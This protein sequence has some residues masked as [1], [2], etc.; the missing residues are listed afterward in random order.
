MPPVS[1]WGTEGTGGPRLVESPWSREYP[2]MFATP[3]AAGS[4]HPL[5]ALSFLADF[6]PPDSL[7][8][9]CLL[10]IP[11]VVLLLGE[12]GGV[13][14]V[15][16]GRVGIVEKRWSSC[17]PV[18][19]GGVI[20]LDGESGF[21]ADVLRAGFHF[22]LWR[23][24]Y[25]LHKVPLVTVAPG[26]IGYVYARGGE[27]LPAGQVLGRVVECDNYQNARAFLGRSTSDTPLSPGQRGR[28]RAI[29]REGTYAMNL[30]LFAVLTEE[31]VYHLNLQGHAELEKL[32]HR[33]HDLKKVG[34]FDP[35]AIPTNGRGIVTV[36]DGPPLMPGEGDAPEVDAKPQD[37][38]AFLQAG[39]KRGRQQ[40]VLIEG[41]YFLNRWFATVE[42]KTIPELAD[43]VG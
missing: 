28:Q 13:R 10:A 2:S 37:A 33:Q 9:F 19:E 21:Q 29:L 40:A 4:S 20:A 11:F 27:R 35:V 41:R 14:Y 15:P 26:K 23:W 42:V 24:H 1:E 7:W 25:R 6:G 38:E 36:H 8:V 22:G 30:A 16:P 5:L 32:V 43:V 31:V 34:G 12:L 39:G 18:P 3:V 17:G